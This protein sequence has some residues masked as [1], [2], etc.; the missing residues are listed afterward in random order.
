MTLVRSTAVAAMDIHSSE[1]LGSSQAYFCNCTQ[2][3]ENLVRSLELAFHSSQSNFNTSANQA[4]QVRI[5]SFGQ[6]MM[7]AI[8]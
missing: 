1:G 7:T 3:T 4:R 2:H 5:H 8:E 6:H